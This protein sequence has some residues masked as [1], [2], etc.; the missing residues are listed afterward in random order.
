[1]QSD[2]FGRLSKIW[3][4][5]GCSTLV[6]ICCMECQETLFPLC[7]LGSIMRTATIMPAILNSG[8]F[9]RYFCR[10]SD[11]AIIAVVVFQ[12]RRRRAA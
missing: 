1:M 8:I 3:S 9:F 11:F 10:Q 5:I 2:D 7:H 6:R 12:H 4:G